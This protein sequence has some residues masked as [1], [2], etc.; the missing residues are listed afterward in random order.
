MDKDHC[1]GH[2][3]FMGIEKKDNPL[4]ELRLILKTKVLPL[5]EEYF[6]GDPERSAWSWARRLSRERTK[7][8][9]GATGDWGMDDYE[10]RRVYALADPL[11]LTIEDFR[12][13]YGE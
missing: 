10:E 2:S 9:S 3:Y 1:I 8:S 6:Y 7:P 13:V 5:L 12:S 11:A 4:E